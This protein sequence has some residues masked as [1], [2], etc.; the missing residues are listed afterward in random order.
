MTAAYR[1]V[2]TLSSTAE[3]GLRTY[4]DWILVGRGRALTEIMISSFRLPP[5]DFEQALALTADA[6]MGGGQRPAPRRGS[7][8]PTA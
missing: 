3:K 4:V 5:A 2:A 1:V 8:V 6:R 7:T